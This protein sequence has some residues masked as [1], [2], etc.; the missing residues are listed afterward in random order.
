[1]AFTLNACGGDGGGGEAPSSSSQPSPKCGEYNHEKKF[2][3]ERGEKLYKYVKINGQTGRLLWSLAQAGGTCQVM[4][5]GM[6]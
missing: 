1:M 4:R 3:D 2:C 6:F 5:S